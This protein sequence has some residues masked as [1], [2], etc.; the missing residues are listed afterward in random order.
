MKYHLSWERTEEGEKK[1]EM[2]YSFSVCKAIYM[3][4]AIAFLNAKKGRTLK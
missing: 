2:Q 3:K 4:L 1:T